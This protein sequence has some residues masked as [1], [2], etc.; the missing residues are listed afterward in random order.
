LLSLN[1]VVSPSRVYSIRKACNA[2]EEANSLVSLSCAV[3][4]VKYH[5]L[6]K[7]ITCAT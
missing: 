6:M 4:S 3:E 7:S 5:G 1:L 2:L